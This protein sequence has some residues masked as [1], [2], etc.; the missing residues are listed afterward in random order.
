MGEI[1]GDQGLQR[2]ALASE[3]GPGIGGWGCTGAGARQVCYSWLWGPA[4]VWKWPAKLGL[5]VYLC[6]SQR[7][8]ASVYK[9]LLRPLPVLK[10]RLSY[11]VLKRVFLNISDCRI[12]CC[13]LSLE[14]DLFFSSWKDVPNHHRQSLSDCIAPA[15][16]HKFSAGDSSILLLWWGRRHGG[17]QRSLGSG[18]LVFLCS[19]HDLPLSVTAVSME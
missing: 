17:G 15:T 2:V 9:T 11:T 6:P 10:V 19:N 12:F 3:G 16:H 13:S 7:L 14:A 5:A 1:T 18:I 4:V 8:L